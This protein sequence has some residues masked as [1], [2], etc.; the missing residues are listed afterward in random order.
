MLEASDAGGNLAGLR[1]PR[2]PRVPPDPR[3]PAGRHADRLRG[4][5]GCGGTPQRGVDAAADA[6]AC[7]A[8]SAAT[9]SAKARSARP[10]S[11]SGV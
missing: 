1:R 5:R 9:A 8:G 6:V 3:R 11:L 4:T 10:G 7:G 2:H